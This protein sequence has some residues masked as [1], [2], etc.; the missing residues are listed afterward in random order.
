MTDSRNIATGVEPDAAV[1]SVMLTYPAPADLS[2]CAPARP[3]LIVS[4]QTEPGAR[5]LSLGVYCEC[6]RT[7]LMFGCFSESQA[8]KGFHKTIPGTAKKSR[9][10]LRSP[11]LEKC[12]EPAAISSRMKRSFELAAIIPLNT[13]STVRNF[14]TNSTR[15]WR[16]ISSLQPDSR[17]LLKMLPGTGGTIDHFLSPGTITGATCRLPLTTGSCNHALTYFGQMMQR[18][19]NRLS[20][21]LEVLQLTTKV[22]VIRGHIEMPMTRE[23]K[24]QCLCFTSFLAA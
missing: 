20:R 2:S 5:P 7:I 15:L 18:I 21:I 9:I 4:P 1:H 12:L 24:E 13:G 14:R 6:S 10:F 11:A 22:L 19:I 23:I 3:G 8:G 16:Y 17:C